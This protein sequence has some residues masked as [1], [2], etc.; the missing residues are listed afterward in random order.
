MKAEGAVP[1]SRERAAGARRRTMR[2]WDVDRR[3]AVMPVPWDEQQLALAHDLAALIN[4]GLVAAVSDGPETRYA[5]S[6][7]EEVLV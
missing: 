4:E 1:R 2:S 3:P 7:G 6:D 5:I